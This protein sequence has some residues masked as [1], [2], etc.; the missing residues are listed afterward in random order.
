MRKSKKALK[1]FDDKRGSDYMKITH[2]QK[3]W[4]F[5]KNSMC[6][7]NA[8][9]P[10]VILFCQHVL[11]NLLNMHDDDWYTVLYCGE[12]ICTFA[13]SMYAK[14][15][16]WFLNWLPATHIFKIAVCEY[17]GLWNG[18][19]KYLL[20]GA[21]RAL[22]AGNAALLNHKLPGLDFGHSYNIAPC[23]HR[24]F[25]VRLNQELRNSFF[26]VS[27]EMIEG[28]CMS[29]MFSFNRNTTIRI[30]AGTKNSRPVGFLL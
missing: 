3:K 28:A 20:T 21:T 12:T 8:D 29:A 11:A 16:R 19:N 23:G 6:L 13:T 18:S 14:D 17:S 22:E 26:Y 24:F 5:P 7:A 9:H 15:P 1:M 30:W 4:W 2:C 25:P 10:S 27:F